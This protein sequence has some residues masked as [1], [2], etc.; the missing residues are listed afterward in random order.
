MFKDKRISYSLT[1]IPLIIILCL[2]VWLFTVIFE[3]EKPIIT[4]A[5][6]PEFLSGSQTFTIKISDMKRGLNKLKV[7]YSQGGREVSVYQKQFPFEGLLN[8]QGVHSFES[9]VVI[10]P[11]SLH[12]AQGRMDLNV[13]VWDYSRRG[14]GDGNMTLAHHK[15]TVD[16]V[17]PAIRAISRMHNINIGGAGLVVYQTSSDTEESGVYV[18][19]HF[20]PG[21]PAGADSKPGIHV[22][23][24]AVPHDSD[25]N[26]SIYLRAKD[27]AENSSNATFYHHL[28]RKKFRKERMNISDRFLKRVLPY[29]SFYQLD[30]E[31][32]DIEKYMKINNDLR[33]EDN[34]KFLS[35]MKNTS[36]EMLW[37]GPCLRLKNAATMARFADHRMYYY[38][39]EKVDEQFHLG[40]DLASL[41][42]SPVAAGNNG[43]VLLAERCGIYGITVVL[44]HGQ[45]LA[46]IYGHLSS[47]EVNTDDVVKKGDIIGYTGQ[48]GLAGGDHLHFSVMV[49]GVFVNPI[50]WWDSHWIKDNITRKL[51]LIN[52]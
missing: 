34:E 12:L 5:P 11:S 14:G 35:L 1:L 38:K 9:E 47:T 20:F 48:T 23:Y 13:H 19:N 41:A 17:P 2:F 30:S 42:N 26:P 40:I 21:F 52:K 18:N 51:A 3:G 15:M 37:E 27:R 22:A 49:N 44:D 36:P 25:L 4:L 45:G 7:S 43:K 24:F 6:R 39:G 28:R 16:T 10:D 29:F 8:R 33:K 46:S 32:N 50:E 31:E